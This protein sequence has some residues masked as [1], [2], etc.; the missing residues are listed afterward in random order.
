MKKIQLLFLMMLSVI[1]CYAA[2]PE[3]IPWGVWI[4]RGPIPF[5]NSRIITEPNGR[6]YAYGWDDNMLFI[7]QYDERY[8]GISMFK[9]NGDA[10]TIEKYEE[11][12][13]GFLFHCKGDGY[14]MN[15]SNNLQEYANYDVTMQVKMVF[16]DEDTCYFLFLP[17]QNGYRLRF[18]EQLKVDY[19]GIPIGDVL[20]YLKEQQK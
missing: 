6:F 4:T 14:R 18:F 19:S 17:D 5:D 12:D 20:Y 13:Y 8:S 3:Y 1:V 9:V 11:T 16:V 2:E 15:K 7:Y 10:A